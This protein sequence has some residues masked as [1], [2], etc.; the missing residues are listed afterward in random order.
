[1]GIRFSPAALLGFERG[2]AELAH[3]LVEDIAKRI[4][5]I[6]VTLQNGDVKDGTIQS[7][8]PPL[9]RL[10]LAEKRRLDEGEEDDLFAG[11]GADIVVQALHPDA[12]DLLDHRF[13]DRPRRFHQL[14]SHLLQEIS[15]LPGLE[16]LDQ[17]LF[18]RGQNP[19]EADNKQITD[20]VGVDVLGA[21]A[22]AFLQKTGHP[23]A[24]GRF[25]FS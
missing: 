2:L 14:D 6:G 15:S 20:Q 4:A 22:H 9:F 3:P 8:S 24:D 7:E 19:L 12:G 1:L 23:M 25:D 18:S 5:S 16:R 10:C 11:Y 17:M 21:A 13:H